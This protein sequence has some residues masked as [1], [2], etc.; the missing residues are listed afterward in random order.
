MRILI[1]NTI[2]F[3]LNGMSTMIMNYYNHFNKDL[4]D[5]DFVV[6]KHIDSNFEK[7]IIYNGS[8]IFVFKNRNKN[9]IQ[10]IWKLHR[11]LKIGEYDVIYINGNSA[12]MAFELLA[13]TG[14]NLKKIVHAHGQT[15][16]HPFLHRFLYPYFIRHYDK[17]FA[18]SKLA[19][20]WLFKGK[21]Y[22]I[23]NNGIDPKKFSFNEEKRNKLRNENL[24][25]NEK[26]ILQV[27]SFTKQKNYEFTIEMFAQLIKDEPDYRLWL[28]GEGP[29]KEKIKKMV[30]LLNISDKVLFF[31]PTI[32]TSDYY[33]AADICIFPSSWEPFGIV[34]LEAQAAGLPVI[35]SDRFIREVEVTHNVFF[36]PINK[37]IWVDKIKLNYD[38]NRNTDYSY[39][40]EK[41][42][43][44]ITQNAHNLET[45]LE[46]MR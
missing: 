12:T 4:F 41:S 42:G 3:N 22:Q 35:L 19:G 8:R 24:I 13:T 18:A 17:A 14:L 38:I 9:P 6:N 44:S 28:L 7:D 40:F 1:V 36:L 39:A 10:Y 16:D 21:K 25:N 29:L 27:G 5:F 46:S 15:T 33:S 23:I 31:E 11:V 26:I 2:P 30:M 37:K 32:H 45:I 20:D 43:Y 34:A